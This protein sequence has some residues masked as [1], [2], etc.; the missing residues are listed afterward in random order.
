[1]KLNKYFGTLLFAGAILVGCS[2]ATDSLKPQTVQEKLEAENTAEESQVTETPEGPNAFILKI[3]AENAATKAL[4]DLGQTLGSEWKQGDSVSVYNMTT[5]EDIEGWLYA[6]A[7]GTSTTF[8]GTVAGNFNQGDILLLQFLAPDYMIQD[9]TLEGLA[10]QCD[11]ATSQVEVTA[12]DPE[13]KTISTEQ[14]IFEKMQA[15]VKFNITNRKNPVEPVNVTSFRGYGKLPGMEIPFGIH[16]KPVAATDELY[17]GIPYIENLKITFEAEGEDGFD[18]RLIVPEVSFEEGLYYRRQLNMKRKA[19]VKAPVAKANLTY[20]TSEQALVDAAHVYWMV[21]GQEV[22]LDEEKDYQDQACVISY[23]V[24]K[25]VTAGTVP[26][27]PTKAENGWMTSIPTQ[28]HA[29]TYYVWTKMTGNYD[30]EDTDVSAEPVKVEIKKAT[31]TVTVTAN[32]STLTYNGSSQNLLSGAATLKIG[33][34][35]VTSATDASNNACSIQYYVSTS[36]TSATGGSWGTSYAATNAKTYYVWVK[37]TG[38]GDINDI[39]AAYKV[40]KGIAKKAPSFSLA[41]SSVTFGQSD[42]VNSTKTVNITYDGDGALSATSSSTSSATVSVANKVVTITRKSGSAGSATI[43]VSAAEG[44]NYTAATSQTISVTLTAN[45]TGVA[46][47]SASVGYKVASNGKAYAPTAS[48]P[49]DYS[50][51]GVIVKSGY[52]MK[53]VDQSTMYNLENCRVEDKHDWA[54]TGYDYYINSLTETKTQKNWILGSRQDYQ[55]I[56]GGENIT[57]I[58]TMLTAAGANPLTVGGV[59]YGVWCYYEDKRFMV[60]TSGNDSYVDYY[61][62]SDSTSSVVRYVRLIFKY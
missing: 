46:L 2:K 49:T 43:T 19:L 42:A 1:M 36:Q 13:A 33:S 52:V 10:A 44:T 23:F 59:G 9:G 34:T 12:I 17:V 6:E 50:L 56:F 27:A 5:K 14:A 48:I 16:V 30:Y 3:E 15:V 62:W 8:S 32:S 45:D 20:N 7:D 22:I 54:E 61:G 18:Y 47:K 25:E 40:S 41:S 58:Q 29:G 21:N 35:N 60:T 31:A 39:A 53:A 51:V 24:K 11:Y 38:N 57:S 26:T 37:V 4:T 55:V 28:I